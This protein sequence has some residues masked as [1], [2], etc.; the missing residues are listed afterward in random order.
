[1]EVLQF[2]FDHFWLVILFLFFFGGSIWGAIEWMIRRGLKHRERMQELKNE[3]LRLQLQI[4]QMGKKES[5][6]VPSSF[7][8]KEVAWEEREY[9]QGYQQQQQQ[10]R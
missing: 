6:Y 9:Y 8:P 1:M 5:P 7:D 4:A 10:N 3:E 2:L